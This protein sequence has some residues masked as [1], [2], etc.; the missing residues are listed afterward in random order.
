MPAPESYPKKS[1]SGGEGPGERCV[2]LETGMRNVPHSG[3]QRAA[4]SAGPGS[5]R[6]RNAERVAVSPPD[7]TIGL[8]ATGT[9]TTPGRDR[10]TVPGPEHTGR[11][12]RRDAGRRGRAGGLDAGSRR[13]LLRA[14]ERWLALGGADPDE[15]GRGRGGTGGRFRAHPSRPVVPGAQ[16]RAGY[17]GHRLVL[18]LVTLLPPCAPPKP[19]AQGTAVPPTD[20][21][22]PRASPATPGSPR[23]SGHAR[24]P[25]TRSVACPAEA[26]GP[27]SSCGRCRRTDKPLWAGLTGPGQAATVAMARPPARPVPGRRRTGRSAQE[28]EGSKGPRR[29][30]CTACRLR[31]AARRCCCHPRR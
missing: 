31:S 3:L 8:P 1:R 12:R 4:R 14:P 17:P 15:R 19:S 10:P 2:L 29:W 16:L 25:R 6:R 9:G 22:Q 7:T 24:R 28:S 27:L 5:R 13:G 20:W 30:R 21:P 11:A 26:A 23:R 18:G